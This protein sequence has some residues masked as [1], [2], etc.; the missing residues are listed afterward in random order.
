MRCNVVA[1]FSCDHSRV[2]CV[3]VRI[4]CGIDGVQIIF[5]VVWCCGCDWNMGGVVYVC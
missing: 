3:H 4:D 5:C 1:V 2:L